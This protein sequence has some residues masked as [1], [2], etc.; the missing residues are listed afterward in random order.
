VLR[1]F[2]LLQAG[3]AIPCW[4]FR[5]GWRASIRFILGSL[6]WWLLASESSVAIFV[7]SMEMP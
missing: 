6:R 3:Q 5:L 4:L 2:V 7:P 1:C